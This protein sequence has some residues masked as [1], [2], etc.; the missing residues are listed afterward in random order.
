MKIPMKSLVLAFSFVTA[1][2]ANGLPASAATISATYS[3]K[4]TAVGA[5]G[6]GFFA[7]DDTYTLNV[8]VDDTVLDNVANANFG[9]FQAVTS[10]NA[11][12]SNGFS[13]TSTSGHDIVRTQ[14]NFGGQDKFDILAG[15]LSASPTGSFTLFDAGITLFDSSQAMLA[16][17]AIPGDLVS[18]VAASTPRMFAL[19]FMGPTGGFFVHS[20]ITSAS[21]VAQTPIPAALPLL[22]SALGG[23]G[24]LGWKRRRVAA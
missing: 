22:A 1:L 8:F 17:D 19:N 5:A 21:A 6:A 3:G 10:I 7:P 20:S 11:T 2:L 18:L 9:D 16:S 12:F 23:L 15:M 14:N 24:L 4:V 13:F